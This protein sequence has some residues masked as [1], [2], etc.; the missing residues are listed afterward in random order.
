MRVMVMVAMMEMRLHAESI[1]VIEGVV[2]IFQG[3][4]L[5]KFCVEWIEI[6]DAS[7]WF[8]FRASAVNIYREKYFLERRLTCR[9]QALLREHFSMEGGAPSPLPFG[10]P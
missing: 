6:L 2:N 7:D 9:A 5:A 3:K 1:R 4:L 10:E 8:E